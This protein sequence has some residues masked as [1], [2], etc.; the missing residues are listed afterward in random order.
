MLK[1]Y[2]DYVNQGIYGDAKLAKK[3]A[4]AFFNEYKGTSEND[5]Y[6][7]SP[8]GYMTDSYHL[9]PDDCD[10]VFDLKYKERGD[11]G[12]FILA[13]LQVKKA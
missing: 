4:K 5:L 8:C 1:K 3:A 6:E 9:W 12:E 10:F 7:Q 2:S 13:G 11:S